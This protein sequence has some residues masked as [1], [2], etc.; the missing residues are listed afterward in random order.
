MD[1]NVERSRS[2]GNL[3]LSKILLPMFLF[4]HGLVIRHANLSKILTPAYEFYRAE[5]SIRFIVIHN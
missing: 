3:V 1:E 2:S 4:T 5:Q